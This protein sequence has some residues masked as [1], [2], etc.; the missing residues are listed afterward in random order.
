[1]PMIATTI[2]NS[3]NEK[4][5]AA[6]RARRRDT[7][8][9]S[10]RMVHIDPYHLG[11]GSPRRPAEFHVHGLTHLDLPELLQSRPLQLYGIALAVD[12]DLLAAGHAGHRAG[13]QEI[14]YAAGPRRR[15]IQRHGQRRDQCRQL[16]VWLF[17]RISHH[18][19]RDCC[20]P[21]SMT[22]WMAPLDSVINLTR[23]QLAPAQGV[24]TMTGDAAYTL[25]SSIPFAV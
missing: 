24:F 1:M 18:E 19:V 21:L 11:R 10:G 7:L 3:I 15:G 8:W 17:H 6:T 4:P 22:L 2:I 9:R 25:P 12:G 16:Q 23:L 20:E 14:R 5:T 13:Y